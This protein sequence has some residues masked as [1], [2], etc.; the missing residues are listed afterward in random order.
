M[1]SWLTSSL[2]KQEDRDVGGFSMVPG[3]AQ[4]RRRVFSFTLASVMFFHETIPRLLNELRSRCPRPSRLNTDCTRFE[5][6][7]R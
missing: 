6:V 5:S 3:L 1:W 7:G 2:G 4:L